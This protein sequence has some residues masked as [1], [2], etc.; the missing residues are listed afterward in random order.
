M[1]VYIEDS[2]LFLLLCQWLPQNEHTLAGGRQ[3]LEIRKLPN[4]QNKNQQI[5][6]QLSESSRNYFRLQMWLGS[7]PG[8]AR[9]GDECPRQG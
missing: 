1:C 6:E 2:P 3:I 7:V 8:K 4:S 9:E 5:E